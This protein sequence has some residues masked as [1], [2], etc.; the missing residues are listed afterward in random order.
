[1]IHVYKDGIISSAH[2]PEVEPGTN[3][4]DYSKLVT[5][6][7]LPGLNGHSI[8]DLIEHGDIDH[9]WVVKT[10]VDFAENVLI[11]NRPIQGEGVMTDNT[12]VPIP[13]KSSRSF[14]VNAFVSDERS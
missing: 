10:P 14:F 6:R 3:F 5:R 13:V 4:V 8:V 7:D 2:T 1:M 12:W 9:V 11:G